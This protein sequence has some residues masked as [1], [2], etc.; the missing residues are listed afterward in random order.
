MTTMLDLRKLQHF[1]QVA[2]LG[3]FTKAAAITATAQSA[4]SRQVGELEADFG[5][6]LLHRTGRGVVPTEL[7]VRMLPRMK[8]LLLEAEQL[9]QDVRASQGKQVGQVDLAVLASLGTSL[10]TPLLSRVS[11]RFPGIQMRVREGL[12]EHIDEWLVTGRIDLGV[13]YSDRR[14]PA[15]GDEL[16]F[17]CDLFLVAGLG[18][19]IARKQTIPLRQLAALPIVMP[20]LPNS[21]RVV[22]EN[23]WK[24]HGVALNVVMEL[25]SIATMKELVHSSQ[26]YTVLPLCAVQREVSSGLLRASRIVEPSIT[27]SVLLASSTQR[28]ISR[29]SVEVARVVRELVKELIQSGQVA[30]GTLG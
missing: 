5:T 15:P 20:G 13:L 8:A 28:P 12:T 24:E 16:L 9:L 2:E 29:A 6:M 27:R 23:V 25:D 14:N 26:R 1:V 22:V 11:D 21:L 19:K 18:D 7:A 3:S 10:L 17:N 4:L 30:G